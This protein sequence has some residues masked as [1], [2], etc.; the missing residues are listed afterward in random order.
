MTGESVAVQFQF[1]YISAK[2]V[3]HDRLAKFQPLNV[4]PVTGGAGWPHVGL[5]S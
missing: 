4:Y 2:G 1:L 3:E 5:C